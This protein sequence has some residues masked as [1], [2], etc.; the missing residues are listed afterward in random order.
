MSLPFPRPPATHT[1]HSLRRLP[2]RPTHSVCAPTRRYI[3]RDGDGTC[4]ALVDGVGK[5]MTYKAGEFFGELALLTGGK[6]AAT[7]VATGPAGSRAQLL[8]LSSE[9]FQRL[10][11]DDAAGTVL[12]TQTQSYKG[13][14]PKV[15][16]DAI[17]AAL[18]GLGAS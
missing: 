11:D 14:N 3:L 18:P 12:K 13:A 6:R 17:L 7:V 15:D 1:Q 2:T 10:T 16:M 5:V 9:D 8:K 4:E